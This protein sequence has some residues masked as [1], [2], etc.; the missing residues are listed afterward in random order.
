MKKMTKKTLESYRKMMDDLYDFMYEV[1]GNKTT[2]TVEITRWNSKGEY[3]AFQIA[4]ADPE[5]GH[6]NSDK[7]YFN[8]A[9]TNCGTPIKNVIEEA[10]QFVLENYKD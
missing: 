7:S 2:F 1:I 5:T 4:I 10:K 9:Y 6:Y 3:L 8:T